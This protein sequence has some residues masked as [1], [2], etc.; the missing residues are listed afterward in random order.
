MAAVFASSCC[1]GYLRQGI[2]NKNAI[3]EKGLSGVPKFPARTA[4]EGSPVDKARAL[5]LDI[6]ES[7]LKDLK[8]RLQPLEEDLLRRQTERM[9]RAKNA[10][11]PE[12]DRRQENPSKERAGNSAEQGLRKVVREPGERKRIRVRD[13]LGF[14]ERTTGTDLGDQKGGPGAQDAP[15]YPLRRNR[16]AGQ[17]DLREKRKGQKVLLKERERE[18]ERTT[19]SP[20]RRRSS[21]GRTRNLEE[22][23][24]RSRERGDLEVDYERDSER[25]PSQQWDEVQEEEEGADNWS[26]LED[27]PRYYQED[28]SWSSWDWNY[29]GTLGSPTTT[30]KEKVRKVKEK[31]KERRSQRA[32]TKRAKENKK[33]PRG[34]RTQSTKELRK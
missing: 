15:K 32:K 20:T 7:Q 25:E 12:R 5:R 14:R 8:A 16:E 9:E 3:S 26:R 4:E 31:E 10:K 17:G 33:L 21:P 29:C 30:L 19:G 13:A 18:R 11:N 22:G 34:E 2:E 24:G 28:W 1:A 23:P 27:T 6:L